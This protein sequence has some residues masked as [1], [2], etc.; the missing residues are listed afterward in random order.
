MTIRFQYRYD[1]FSGS[2]EI[3]PNYILYYTEDGTEWLVPLN[4]GN[5]I[6][7][8]IYLP[9]LAAGNVPEQPS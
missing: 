7:T 1:A 5:W 2:S 9:W 8:D 4:V 6:E 3:D